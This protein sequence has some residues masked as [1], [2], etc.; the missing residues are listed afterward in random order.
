MAKRQGSTEVK[1]ETMSAETKALN[2]AIGRD[3]EDIGA[4]A[5][6]KLGDGSHL[7]VEGISTGALARLGPGRQR[8][9]SRANR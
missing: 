6:M 8:A 4:G 7:E 5:I 3:R 9:A 2:N 1:P